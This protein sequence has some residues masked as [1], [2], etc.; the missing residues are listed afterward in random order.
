[1]NSAN[2]IHYGHNY[3]PLVSTLRAQ[4]IDPDQL[5]HL[6]M[7]GI[8]CLWYLYCPTPAEHRPF[9]KGG[10]HTLFRQDLYRQSSHWLVCLAVKDFG[11]IL[12]PVPK[13]LWWSLGV[14]YRACT[15]NWLVR[16]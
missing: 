13:L 4:A 3:V 15:R 7:W 14:P 8:D 11:H 12:A 6:V 1:M 5:E 16:I 10:G 9:A 2:R